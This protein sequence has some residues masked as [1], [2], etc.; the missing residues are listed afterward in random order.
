M[1]ASYLHGVETIELERGTRPIRSVRTAVIGLVGTAPI[2]EV[3]ASARSTNEPVLITNPV[4][5][6]KRFG[7]ARSGYTIPQA[8]RAIFDQGA[9]IVV[10][11]NV[12]DPA[13]HKTAVASA[14]SAFD[15]K[16]VITLP[17]QG[18][19]AVA[20][21]SAEGDITYLEGTDYTVDAVAG[22]IR[23]VEGGQ[24]AIEDQVQ[25]SYDRPDPSEVTAVE[26]IGAVDVGGKRGGMKALAE[27][28]GRYGF[29]P[30]LLI[31][32]V[33][34]TQ[35]SVAAEL[36]AQATSLRGVALVDAPIGTTVDGT[37][38]GR[39]SAGAINFQSASDRVIL[40]YPHVRVY[41]PAANLEVLEPL[42]QRL[43]GVIAA[44]D[45][46]LGYWWSPSNAEIRGIIGLER[47]LTAGIND[48]SS[49]VNRL[50]EAGITTVFTGFGAGFRSW[51]NRSAAHP[52][53]THP[54]N[55]VAVRR[56]ADILHESIEGAMLQFLDQPITDAL[57]DS[58]SESVGA[59]IR[60]LIGR[61][62]LIDGSCTFDPAKNPPAEIAAGHLT[63]DVS[64]MPPTPA[65]RITFESFIDTSLLRSLGAGGE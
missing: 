43:A 16:G 1:A 37:I 34:C 44:R 13:K 54:R 42:S 27:S 60:T 29:A 21:K 20:V 10:V 53:L 15:S 40:C 56:T 4:D 35:Q 6:A 7:T 30:K 11:V 19:A 28:A 17:H 39:G 58:I 5:A 31:S 47:Q 50:N 32:P 63:F 45:L 33:Y 46:E 24:L 59:F 41:D 38:A 64:F 52:S 62:A 26:V 48:P 65:E 9:G 57:V 18:V 12:F 51:G 2:W 3:D 49:E 23:R 22:V 14:P 8:L 61:G 55:F 25:V 36:E